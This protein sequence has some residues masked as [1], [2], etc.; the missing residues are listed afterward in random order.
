MEMRP[1]YPFNVIPGTEI[2]AVGF[3]LISIVVLYSVEL[4]LFENT[5]NVANYI[6]IAIHGCMNNHIYI[7]THT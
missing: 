7:A 3:F 1:G 5:T 2:R 6:Y 4:L